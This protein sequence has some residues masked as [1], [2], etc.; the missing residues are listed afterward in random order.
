MDLV[1]KGNVAD[2]Q[3][4]VMTTSKGST[5]TLVVAVV[6]GALLL[7]G[8]ARAQDSFTGE[9]NAGRQASEGATTALAKGNGLY[10]CGA[11]AACARETTRREPTVYPKQVLTGIITKRGEGL[12]LFRKKPGSWILVEEDP[13]AGC[14]SNKAP[15]GPCSPKMYFDITR[16]SDVYKE[17]GN[18]LTKVSATRLKKGQRVRADYTGYDVADSYP[19]QTDA[20][21]VVILQSP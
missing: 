21:K 12:F 2:E 20:R 19:S 13:D 17:R 1:E 4:S 15:M 6:F 14:R 3:G 5:P 7:T 16:N 8:C 11:H 18:T 9:G 10:E